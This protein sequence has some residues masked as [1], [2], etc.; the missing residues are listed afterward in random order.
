MRLLTSREMMWIAGGTETN[1]LGEIIVTAPG[2][3]G[4][5]PYDPYWDG[6]GDDNGPDDPGGGGGGGGSAGGGGAGELAGAIGEIL[7]VLKDVNW[8]AVGVNANEAYL[9]LHGGFNGERIDTNMLNTP[10]R[11]AP[12]SS[13]RIWPMARSRF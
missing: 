1:S 9:A 7:K 11:Q 8:G 3:D 2:D 13:A 6:G 5:Q 4:G 10:I 12:R